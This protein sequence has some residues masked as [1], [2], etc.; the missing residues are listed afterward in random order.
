[1]GGGGEGVRGAGGG[2]ERGGGGGVG[3]QETRAQDGDNFFA[4]V[5][6][7]GQ[8][9]AED[10]AQAAPQET[11][12]NRARRE[13][14]RREFLPARDRLRDAQEHLPVP[15]ER[16]VKHAAT[17]RQLPDGPDDRL[18]RFVDPGGQPG[19]AAVIVTELVRE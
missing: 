6:V 11:G 4:P 10:R 8:C 2:G 5:A 15:D 7:V 18:P 13:R 3:R 9:R 17:P 12:A 14:V 1:G 16:Q 19:V